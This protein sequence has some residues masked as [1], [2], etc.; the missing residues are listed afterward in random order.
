MKVVASSAMR[1][2]SAINIIQFVN[3]VLKEL[4]P[5][6]INQLSV[7]HVQQ[8]NIASKVA[9]QLKVMD[10]VLQEAIRHSKLEYPICARLVLLEHTTRTQDQRRPVLA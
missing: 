4:T 1:A 3:D 10:G 7:R 9:S 2:T 5:K 8:A 6:A